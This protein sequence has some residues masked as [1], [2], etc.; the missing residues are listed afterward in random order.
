[1]QNVVAFVSMKDFPNRI[2]ELRRDA[3]LT[4]QE[5]ADRVKCS[6][7]H[8]SGLERGT[9]E[10]SLSWMRRISEVLG[11]TP[12]ELLGDQ[13]NPLRLSPEERKL[14]ARYRQADHVTRE[15]VERVTDALIPFTAEP[16]R[17]S[18]AA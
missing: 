12:A 1:M 5:L 13:D 16:A 7:M 9:R 15:Q 8:I 11:V 4:Q 3:G 6:K 17:K 2:N 18:D 10:L 14:V